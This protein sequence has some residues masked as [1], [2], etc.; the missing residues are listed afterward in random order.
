MISRNYSGK[1]DRKAI[2]INLAKSIN[3]VIFLIHFKLILQIS[4]IL[5]TRTVNVALQFKD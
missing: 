4:S 3:K 5:E 2:C 1:K